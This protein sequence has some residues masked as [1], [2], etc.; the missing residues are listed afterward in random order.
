MGRVV[1]ETWNG[2]AEDRP[3][4]QESSAVGAVAGRE[5]GFSFYIV[6]KCRI[7]KCLGAMALL[8]FWPLKS[9]H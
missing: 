9:V 3:I 4:P 5:I 8:A 6:N 7:I 1:F 2:D